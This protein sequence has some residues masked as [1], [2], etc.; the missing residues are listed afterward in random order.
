MWRHFYCGAASLPQ[1]VAGAFAVASLLGGILKN[2]N[3]S[4]R[5]LAALVIGLVLMVANLAWAGS[6]K[7]EEITSGKKA[8]TKRAALNPTSK[9]KT[10]AAAS[11]KR[12]IR[13]EGARTRLARL[14]LD[15]A[16]AAEIQQALIARGYLN[17]PAT[18]VW[19]DST[20]A[21]MR[22]FQAENQ[23]P[24]TGLPEAKSL[25]K[26]GLGPHPLPE[27]LDPA[28]QARAQVMPPGSPDVTASK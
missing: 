2:F 28:A 10:S 20:R 22:R 18:G 11:K 17:Q 6:G 15:P 16:R 9:K 27:E 1:T 4:I 23:F 12:R 24:T 3:L 19:D 14:K 13:R 21:A 25:M 8:A 26:L 7:K 5:G